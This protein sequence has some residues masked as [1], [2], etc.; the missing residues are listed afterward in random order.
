M[1]RKTLTHLFGSTVFMAAAAMAHAS[2]IDKSAAT[3][4]SPD[5]NTPAALDAAAFDDEAAG[6]QVGGEIDVPGA[7]PACVISQ[8]WQPPRSSHR[9]RVV[10]CDQPFPDN[11][12]A[13]DD[14]QCEQG[15]E[16]VRLRWWGVLLAP[17]QA[18]D[19]HYYIAIYE[20][21]GNCRPDTLVYEACVKPKTQWIDV[22]CTGLDVYSFRARIPAFTVQAGQRYWLQ[23]SEDD[24]DSANP[25]FD[26]FRWSGRQP[27]N[28]CPALQV[29]VEGQ[30]HGPL[31]DACDDAV[32]DLS[33]SLIVRQP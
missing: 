6:F 16:A 9:S 26:D 5:V 21:N 22:D 15:G 27:V 10:S 14:F 25:G 30:P 23:I 18:E 1:S 32:V 4:D 19:R 12:V 33:F 24:S 29:D 3:A 7:P 11:L 13:M 17:E 2:A 31:R 20:D 8:P 28:A